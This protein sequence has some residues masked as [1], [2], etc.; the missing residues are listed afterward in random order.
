MPDNWDDFLQSA[1]K[2]SFQNY[3]IGQGAI[4]SLMSLTIKT[5]FLLLKV[6]FGLL[7]SL[8]IA[9][10]ALIPLGDIIGIISVSLLMA[11]QS[12]WLGAEV[13]VVAMIIDQP[14]NNALAPRI[15]SGLIG[16]NP[17]WIIIFLLLGGKLGGV[18]GLILAVSLAGAI[19]RIV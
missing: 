15:S 6:P 1:L 3:F 2:Q 10:L 7:F 19:K 18:L 17:V 13:L 12:V 9:V 4:A 5:A 11:L 8:G 16:L 14:I